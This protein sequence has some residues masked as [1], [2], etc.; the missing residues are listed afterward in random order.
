MALNVGRSLNAN[1][2]SLT[3]SCLYLCSCVCSL[4]CHVLFPGQSHGDILRCKIAD[5][6]PSVFN[7]LYTGNSYT[8]TKDSCKML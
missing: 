7:P 6:E 1:S 4:W 8:G 2:L 3:H 5:A